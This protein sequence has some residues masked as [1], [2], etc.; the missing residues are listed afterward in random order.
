MLK[1]RPAHVHHSRQSGR[2]ERPVQPAEG[3]DRALTKVEGGGDEMR[4]MRGYEEVRSMKGKG[5][6]STSRW[7]Q[8]T[9][10]R[11]NRPKIVS[12][13]TPSITEQPA[14]RDKCLVRLD[15]CPSE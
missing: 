5:A 1:P 15:S 9:D 8:S 12:H 2:L 13:Q 11:L 3:Y 4:E 6:D 7:A 10:K 14:L